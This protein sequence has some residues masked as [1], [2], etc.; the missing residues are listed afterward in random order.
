MISRPTIE[1]EFIVCIHVYHCDDLM[2]YKKF[3]N[4]HIVF[5]NTL[6]QFVSMHICNKSI[7]GFEGGN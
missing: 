3:N 5:N 4:I 2:D 6:L 1:I 7:E